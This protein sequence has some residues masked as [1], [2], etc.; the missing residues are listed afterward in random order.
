MTKA[1]PAPATETPVA[2]PLIEIAKHP[3]TISLFGPA[4]NVMDEF[5]ILARL[6]Y[7]PHPDLAM[8]YFPGGAMALLLQKGDPMPLAYQRAKEII[9][10]EAAKEAAEFDKR[11][12]QEAERLHAAQLQADMD[13]RVAAAQAIADEQ[14]ARIRADAE[15]QVARIVATV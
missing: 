3:D 11:V 7:R 5:T 1:A 2:T 8:R 6:G 4:Y 9:A 13:A 14:V 12:K 10:L 15:A